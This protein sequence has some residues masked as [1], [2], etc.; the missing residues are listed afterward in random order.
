MG[1]GGPLGLDPV[2]GRGRARARAPSTAAVCSVAIV[3]VTVSRA[4]EDED[5]DADVDERGRRW[6]KCEAQRVC[7][8]KSVTGSV[9]S[10]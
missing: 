6:V 1:I 7:P 8:Q 4:A 10:A 5:A 3:S 2:E 9:T